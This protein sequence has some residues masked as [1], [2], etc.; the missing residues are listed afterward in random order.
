MDTVFSSTSMLLLLKNMISSASATTLTSTNA[1]NLMR[2]SHAKR[3]SSVCV[4]PS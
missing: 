4:S 1:E 2:L 3:L